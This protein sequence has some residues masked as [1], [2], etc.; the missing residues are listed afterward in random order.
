MEPI[1]CWNCFCLI[2]DDGM[3]CGVCEFDGVEKK[4]GHICDW[5]KD[6]P[7]FLSDGMDI[8]TGRPQ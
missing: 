3:A 5:P 6:D 2:D 1:S 7:S 4:Y 8:R